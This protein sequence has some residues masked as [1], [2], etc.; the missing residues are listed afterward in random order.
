[1]PANPRYRWLD[2]AVSGRPSPDAV[3]RLCA[4]LRTW[5]NAG[6]AVPLDRCLGLPRKP[7]TVRLMLR[8]DYLRAAAACMPRSGPWTTASTLHQ[9]AR[10]F[11]LR[12]WPCWCDL[13]DPPERAD[14]VERLLWRAA[15]AGGGR[16][17]GARRIAQILAD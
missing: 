7:E 12:K 11:M 3:A 17:P 1:M 13:P 9:A 8:D 14:D 16:L 10:I 2:E 6:G 4:G 15:R 5:W